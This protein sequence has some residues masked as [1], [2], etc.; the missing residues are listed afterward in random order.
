[1]S[2]TGNVLG[3]IGGLIVLICHIIMIVKMFQNGQT[4]LGI[5]A[6]VLTCCGLGVLLTLIYGWI[7]AGQWNIQTLMI[8]Y[9][10]AFILWIVGG[11]MAPPDID[12]F[13]KQLGQ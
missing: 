13:K 9:T 11:A 5:V 1:M 12:W 2:T 6:I 8:I 3:G 4:G 7:K 10:I